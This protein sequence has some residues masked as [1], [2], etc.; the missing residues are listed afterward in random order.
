MGKA[1]KRVVL[2][3]LQ[4]TEVIRLDERDRR[5]VKELGNIRL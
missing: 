3:A 4:A 5:A 1:S 2:G